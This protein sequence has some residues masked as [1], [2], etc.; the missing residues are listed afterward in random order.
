MM[1]LFWR[2]R[3]C[4]FAWWKGQGWHWSYYVGQSECWRDFYSDEYSPGAAVVE[5]LQ[6]GL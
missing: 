5:D 6:A 4:T 2:I 1:F 3:M